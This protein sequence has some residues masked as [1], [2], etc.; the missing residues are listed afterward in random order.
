MPYLRIQ[1]IG[2]EVGEGHCAPSIF[3]CYHLNRT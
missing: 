1:D 3:R 2:T